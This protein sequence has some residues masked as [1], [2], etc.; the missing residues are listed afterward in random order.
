ML[1]MVLRQLRGKQRRA[2][3][4]AFAES[5]CQRDVQICQMQEKLREISAKQLC[6]SNN[7]CRRN[8][9][10]NIRVTDP[11][12][13]VAGYVGSVVKKDSVTSVRV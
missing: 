3:T 2:R 5:I 13:S 7:T 12:V 1:Q 11:L 4:D 6:P 9:V 10:A 8:S